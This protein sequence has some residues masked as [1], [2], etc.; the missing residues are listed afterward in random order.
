MS[1]NDDVNNLNRRKF[2]KSA[3][4][5][6]ATT[7]VA[8]GTALSTTANAHDAK[9]S[10]SN[11]EFD[12][13]VVVIGGGYAGV[14]AA[15]DAKKNGQSVLV[16]E[17]RNRLGGRT[18]A[19]ELD[20]DPVELGGLWV[21]NTQP[22][23]WAEIERYGMKIKETPG[24]AAEAMFVVEENGKR[25]A[26]TLEQFGEIIAGWE[27]YNARAREIVPRPYDILYNKEA[28]LAADKV[29]AIDFLDQNGF[30][31]LQHAFNKCMIEVVGHRSPMEV[32]YIDVMRLHL[33][34]GGCFAT[35]MDSTTR[36]KL[37]DGTNSL[38]EKMID[39]GKPEVRLSTPVK[40]VQDKGNKVVVTT[41]R[42]EKITCGS[43][44]ST[45]PM[46]SITQVAFE[47]A[48]PKAVHQVAKERAPGSGVKL[49]IKV[50][51]DIGNVAS[52]APSR[53]INFAMTYQQ[54]KD[55]TILVAFGNDPEKLD[56]YDDEAIEEALSL[57]IPDVKVQS[58]MAYDW[59]NDPY[60]MGTWGIYQTGWLNKYYQDL[61][62]EQ[63]R[64][65]FASGDHGEGWRGTIDGAIAA[66]AR[67]ARKVNDLLNS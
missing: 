43:V 53:A 29:N 10:S 45:L 46:N 52:L 13:D 41:V 61:Q 33:V 23:V 8:A 12:Y 1:K 59:N 36:F 2:L 25:N 11:S 26:L 32:S 49:Y 40:S 39:D 4:T 56:I 65:F 47:P 67:A 44:I 63:G 19:S 16:L 62:K 18:F 20:G 15:R 42:N 9:P 34:G 55:Y 24:A 50:K 21:H 17:A 6:G 35:F 38:I 60:S 31:P 58:T 30:T 27:K 37:A 7:V 14:T 22:F 57:L 3:A 5:I 48:L 28:A 54:A 51:G 66:G 64:V